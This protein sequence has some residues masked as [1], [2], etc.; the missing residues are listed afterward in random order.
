MKKLIMIPVI[1][2]ALGACAAKTAPE[3]PQVINI[4]VDIVNVEKTQVVAVG[5]KPSTDKIVH[6][7]AGDPADEALE[8]VL[9]YTGRLK[10]YADYAT[11]QLNQCK[12]ENDDMR[13]RLDNVKR[14]ILLQQANQPR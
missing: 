4:P 6:I 13:K 8:D 5:D 1:A 10:T 11:V 7:R 12:L 2:L 14:F 3:P 9:D